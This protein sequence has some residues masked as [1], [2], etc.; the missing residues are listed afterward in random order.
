MS[1]I[2]PGKQQT[3]SAEL[4]FHFDWIILS[5]DMTPSWGLI[6][7]WQ[8]CSKADV[9]EDDVQISRECRHFQ[10]ILPEADEG[11]VEQTSCAYT[12]THKKDTVTMKVNTESVMVMNLAS[13]WLQHQQ[14]LQ[15][16]GSCIFQHQLPQQDLSAQWSKS[17]PFTFCFTEMVLFHRLSVRGKLIL[18]TE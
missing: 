2:W 10:D 4:K 8:T 5:F 11:L 1:S 18:L 15:D 12:H 13:F 3:F 9:T 7:N 6:K 16:K 17:L 14:F